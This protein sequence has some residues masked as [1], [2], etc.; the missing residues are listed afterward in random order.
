[1]APWARNHIAKLFGAADRSKQAIPAD[2]QP[3][4]SPYEMRLG[5]AV[6]RVN[7]AARAERVALAS[8]AAATIGVAIQLGGAWPGRHWKETTW[9]GDQRLPP[10]VGSGP[11][12]AAGGAD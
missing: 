4:G 6:A 1:M 7:V 5:A 12:A 9:F 2:E 10:T 8:A 3:V 11:C